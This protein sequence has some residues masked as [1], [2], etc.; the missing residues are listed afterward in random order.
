MIDKAIRSYYK[1]HP[2]EAKEYDE[3]IKRT[4]KQYKSKGYSTDINNQKWSLKGFL[5][6][7]IMKNIDHHAILAPGSPNPFGSG[8]TQALLDIQASFP[9]IEKVKSVRIAMYNK[10]EDKYQWINVE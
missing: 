4:I 9:N 10:K 1:D 8:S 2:K 5:Q 3:K 7:Y 6:R